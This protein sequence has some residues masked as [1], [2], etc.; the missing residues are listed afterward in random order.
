MIADKRW[1]QRR[2]PVAVSL[3]LLLALAVISTGCY[4]IPS[5]ESVSPLA[6]P[7][8]MESLDLVIVHSNDT[9]GYFTSCG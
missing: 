6:S 5:L 2:Q 4:A 7:A 9:W 3:A 1:K 8:V